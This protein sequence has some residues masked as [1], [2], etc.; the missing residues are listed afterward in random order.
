MAVRNAAVL[1]AGGGGRASAYLLASHGLAVRLWEAP[2]FA[3]NLGDLAGALRQDAAPT[4][5]VPLERVTTDLP[6]AIADA[7]LIVSC[8]QRGS[9][10]FI[11]EQ[12]AA[13]MT[14]AQWLLINPGSLGGALEIAAIFRAHGRALPRIAETATLAHCARPVPGG[15]RTTLT[16]RH[17]FCAALPAARTAEMLNLLAPFYP[18]LVPAH[19]VVETGLYN[20]NP[21]LHPAIALLNAAALERNDG[22]FRF[23]G[24]GMSPAVAR[25]IEAV[26][27]ERQA[28]AHA[29]GFA[30]IP[31]PQLSVMQGY[32]DHGDYLNCYRDSGVFAP[33]I[34]PNT[35]DH[36]YM[37][38]DVGEGLVTWLALA[39]VAGVSLPTVEALV[40]LAE[41]ITGNDYRRAKAERL[42]RIGLGGMAREEMLNYVL[43][44]R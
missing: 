38:E 35:L 17:V 36:R 41:T 13:C 22:T 34:A 28:L 32:A 44:G 27:T 9:H 40:T 8:V 12:L 1:G 10:R 16:V 33:L 14:D 4:G 2:Q 30:L 23:Y 3:A 6:S 15:V 31:E 7:D 21:V 25:L 39:E 42:A 37:H 20:G 19:S 5:E 43:S 29:F 18:H 26:D 11:G 24:D